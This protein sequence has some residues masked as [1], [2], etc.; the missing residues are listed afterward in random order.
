[1]DSLN[2]ISRVAIYTRVSTEEQ[3]TEGFSL[4]A[5][6]DSLRRYCDSKG[7]EVYD[8]YVDGGY[9]GKNFK[10]PEMQRLLHDVRDDKFEIVLAVAVDRISR[11]NRDVLTFVDCELHPRGKKLLISTCD[12][13]SSTEIGHMFI[14][15]LGTFAEYE[16]RLIV[17]RVKKGMEQ[18]AAEGKTNGGNMLGY[19]S[20]DGKLMVNEDEAEVVREI[21]E[22]RVQGHGYKKIADTLNRKGKKTKAIKSKQGNNFSINAIKQ[23]LENEKYTGV[24]TWGKVRDWSTN[25]RKGKAVPTKVDGEHEA[26]IDKEL[27]AKAQK[28]T[29][30]KR[31]SQVS[32]SNFKGEFILT[33][34]LRCPCCGAGTVM[35]KSK[36]RDGTGYHLYYM[37]GNYHTK[38]KSVCGSNV[39]RKELVEGQ[40]LEFIRTILSNEYIAEGI[41][42]RLRNKEAETT[43]NLENDLNIQRMYASNWPH[44]ELQG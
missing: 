3:S 13:D 7:F 37:C 27:W 17:T 23:I 36:K 10:R 41:M 22:L 28:V 26:I 14:S 29:Q 40:V 15:L 5:Q 24:M 34:L 12:I 11:N 38:G 8:T 21:F 9:S 16:R 25:R 2:E 42:N 39:I 43:C 30:I 32:Q 31:E 18:R 44:L 20:V 19:D 1:M 6:E 35:H 4:A 33:G